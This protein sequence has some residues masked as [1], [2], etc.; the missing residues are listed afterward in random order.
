V[1]IVVVD[2]IIGGI[3]R[4]MV[5]PFKNHL[6]EEAIR[7][8][9]GHFMRVNSGFDEEG[10]STFAT[11]GLDDLALKERSARI[12]DALE[13]VLPD[14][15]STAA[16]I[17]VASLEPAT[18]L[19]IGETEGG[20]TERGI[21]G[22]PIMPMAEYIARHGQGHV[23][24]SLDA[25]RDMTSRFS[26]EFAIRSFLQNHQDI[27]LT[28]LAGWTRDQN[29]HVRRLVS[30]G[31]RP[32][33]P[34][35]VRLTQFVQDPAP[36][37]ELLEDLKDDPS[38]YVRRSV[39]NNL[40]DIAKDHP[41]LVA[42]IARMWLKDAPAERQHLVRHGLRSLIKAGHP[43]ALRSL[44]YGPA[45]VELLR[46]ELRAREV[47]MGGVVEFEIEISST[48]KSDQPLIIDYAVHHMRA[49]GTITAKVF[50]WKTLTLKSG[51]TLRGTRRHAFKLITTRRYYPGR[52]RVEIQVN[53]N[54][55]G[56]ADFELQP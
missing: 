48:A 11:N 24:L 19:S 14:D 20:V 25:L 9:A 18:D 43:G 44:G 2:S 51:E 13:R 26:S 39:A 40:N 5:E 29:E 46:F 36:V 52:H 6:G 32:R 22:W 15:F 16:K 54:T 50:K 17:L 34:W 33:L 55:L 41:D 35:G 1:E 49:G 8:M 23:K 56:G 47:K 12:T 42:D 31:T 45:I 37:V 4:T 3:D 10:F 21:R 53:G 7:A 28:T 30:E 27:T 38:E